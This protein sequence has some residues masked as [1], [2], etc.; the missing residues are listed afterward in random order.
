MA[1]LAEKEGESLS[2][3]RVNFLIQPPVFPLGIKAESQWFYEASVRA[4]VPSF[5]F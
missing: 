5:V 4:R 1:T 3:Y 2:D